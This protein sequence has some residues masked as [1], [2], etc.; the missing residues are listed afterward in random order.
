MAKPIFVKFNVPEDLANKVLEIVEVAK[1]TGKI[2]RGTNESTKALE[3]GGVELVVL[4]EDVSPPEI[5][6]HIPALC[7]ERNVAYTYVKTKRDLGAAAGL[8]VSAACVAILEAGDARGD[9]TNLLHKL[10]ELKKKGK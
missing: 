5:V 8:N 9:V 2:R 4:A 10:K 6:A 3:H 7:E 1:N